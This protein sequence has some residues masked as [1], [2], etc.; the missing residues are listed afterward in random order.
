MIP[1]DIWNCTWRH[2]QMETFS[3]LQAL[4]EGNPTV[5]SGLPLQRPVTRSFDVF[6]D[7][8]LN[9]WLS[10]Q[11]RCWWFESPSRSLWHHCN[12]TALQWLRQNIDQ[13]FKPQ[14]ICH[15]SPWW[16]SY[17]LS[18]EEFGDGNWLSDNGTTLH[19]YCTTKD[20]ISLVSK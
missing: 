19:V 17:G 5:T 8:S 7:V 14:K 1:D 20:L 13:S 10:K 6:F 15:N 12:D 16:V 9:K 4:F 11:S 3:V 2:H 18:C